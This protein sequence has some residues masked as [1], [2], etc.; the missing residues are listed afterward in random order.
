[1]GRQFTI[2]D[3]QFQPKSPLQKDDCINRGA[4]YDCPNRSTLSAVV[5]G[6][7]NFVAEIRSCTD[8]KCKARAAELAVV[9]ANAWIK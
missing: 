8:E 4:K 6:G 7:E 1:M 5:V 3:V 2:D 9:T